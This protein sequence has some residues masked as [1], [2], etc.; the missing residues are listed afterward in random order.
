[1]WA[2]NALHRTLSHYQVAGW[3]CSGCTGIVALSLVAAFA[4]TQLRSRVSSPSVTL[5]PSVHR[6]DNIT[7]SPSLLDELQAST[8]PLPRKLWPTMGGNADD[9]YSN[10]SQATFDKL[11]GTDQMA[12]DKLKQGIDSFAADQKKLEEQLAKLAHASQ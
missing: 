4:V 5:L 1:M 8:E 9:L 6:C 3:Q 11:H 10:M 7:I 12:V 2:L